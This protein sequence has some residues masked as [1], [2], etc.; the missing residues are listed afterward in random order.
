MSLTGTALALV[1]KLLGPLASFL[2]GR[3]L[4]QAELKAGKYV[5][6]LSDRGDSPFAD[7]HATLRVRNRRATSTTIFC[8]SFKVKLDEAID[9][10][11]LPQ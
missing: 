9:D 8:E 2:L 10:F 5:V 7:I 6:Y 3:W 11:N 4:L 1:A